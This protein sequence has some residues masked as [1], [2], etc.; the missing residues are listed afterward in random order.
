MPGCRFGRATECRPRNAA[1]APWQHCRP[2]GTTRGI[3]WL[4]LIGAH[5]LQFGSDDAYQV[6]HAAL[7][8]DEASCDELSSFLFVARAHIDWAAGDLQSL[9][10][11]SQQIFRLYAAPAMP[12]A[13]I[14][15]T[16]FRGM[17]HYQRNNLAAAEADFDSL[18]G[19]P[20]AGRTRLY[21]HGACGLA[22]TYQAQHRPDRAGQVI[23]ELSMFALKLRDSTSQLLVQLIQAELA[24]LQG[25]DDL[26]IRLVNRFGSNLPVL[27]MIHLFAPHMTVAKV[28]VAQH[29]VESLHKAEE[30]LVQLAR[31]LGQ[32]AQ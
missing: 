21:L 29:T 30:L 6:A 27:P 11:T 26:A 22:L 7:Q 14:Y 3:A 12:T 1:S 13:A 25:N 8:G 15:A 19:K 2:A 31:L 4:Q 18:M 17:V 24:F 28:L 20:Y 10:Q 5:L 9:L 16:Y 23:D 32:D